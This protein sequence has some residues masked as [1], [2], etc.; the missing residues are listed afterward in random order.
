ML[1]ELC[2][3]RLFSPDFPFNFRH[4]GSLLTV[5]FLVA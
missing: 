5:Y 2:K 4:L 3:E 1:G